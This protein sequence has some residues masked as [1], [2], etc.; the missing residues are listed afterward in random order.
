MF[1]FFKKKENV[2]QAQSGI[3]PVLLDLRKTLYTNASLDPLLA[4]LGDD[5]K[6]VFPWRNFVAVNEALKEGDKD[7]AILRLKE[8]V[9]ADGLE[10]RTRLQAWHTLVSLGEMPVDTLR[11]YTQAVVIE[12]HTAKGLDIVA[13]YSDSSARYWNP[14]GGGVIWDARDPEIDQLIFNLLSV[15][16]EITKRIGVGLRDTLPVPEKGHIRIFIMAYDGSTV[17]EQP[18]EQL[19]KDP[20]GRV[21]I[22]AGSKLM[23]GLLKKQENKNEVVR[24]SSSTEK[25][26]A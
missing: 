16:F 8:I 6:S 11:G 13:A 25:Q 4:R 22:D 20:M 23:K 14:T 19:S 26:K 2:Q 10:T 12:N 9:G 1:S 17:G 18:Y 3:S 15:G 7:R 24:Y 5:S 21:A